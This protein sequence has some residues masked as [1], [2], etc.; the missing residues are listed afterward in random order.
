MILKTRRTME[1]KEERTKGDTLPIEKETSRIYKNPAEN[2]IQKDKI[3]IINNTL[4]KKTETL[5]IKIG[6]KI[7]K[8]KDNTKGEGQTRTNHKERGVNLNKKKRFQDKNN[9]IKEKEKR[10]NRYN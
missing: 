2:N 3:E 1:D 10:K 8:D 9:M 7:G 5:L 4:I 6:Q